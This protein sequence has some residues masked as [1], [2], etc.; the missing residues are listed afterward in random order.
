MTWENIKEM[1]K[2]R[3]DWLPDVVSIECNYDEIWNKNIFKILNWSWWYSESMNY[4]VHSKLSNWWFSWEEEIKWT[5][6]DLPEWYKKLFDF[7]KYNLWEEVFYIE[8]SRLYK[9]K[10]FGKDIVTHSGFDH[11][12]FHESSMIVY[13]FKESMWW[14]F[15]YFTKEE[16]QILTWDEALDKLNEYTTRRGYFRF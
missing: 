8:N 10:V 12:W 14:R 15:N 6:V 9:V 7:G 3:I 1:V 16:R 5:L 11:D 4:L 13:K 2:K